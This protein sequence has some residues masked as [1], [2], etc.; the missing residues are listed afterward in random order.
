MITVNG[1][2][3]ALED[4]SWVLVDQDSTNGTTVNGGAEP[5]SPHTA[6]PLNDG[7]RP[8]ATAVSSSRAWGIV[9]RSTGS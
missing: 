3:V 7:D 6:V 8:F 1:V 9:G 4:G 2:R 5:I